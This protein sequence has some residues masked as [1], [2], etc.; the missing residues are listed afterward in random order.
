MANIALHD[1]GNQEVGYSKNERADNNMKSKLRDFSMRAN[2]DI[3]DN[4]LDDKLRDIERKR[5]HRF[6]NVFVCRNQ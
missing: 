5:R 1:G 6:V 4:E 3:A 2:K